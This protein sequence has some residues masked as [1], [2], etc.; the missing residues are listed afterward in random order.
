V[1]FK[2]LTLCRYHRG[3]LD[4]DSWHAPLLAVGWLERPH[5]HTRGA[6]PLDLAPRLER[7]VQAAWEIFPQEQFRGLHHCSLCS[8]EPT[9]PPLALSHINLLIPGNGVIYASPAGILHYIAE[10][11]Y[12]PPPEF[13]VA[14]TVCPDY[15]TDAYLP[16]L[17]Q[18][19]G[20]QPTLLETRDW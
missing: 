2:D 20:G 12:L 11:T 3:T 18:A 14:V 7:F 10:H 15:G 16:A 9:A 19:N 13:I 5:R 4:A 1:Y 8:A 17:R 6:A